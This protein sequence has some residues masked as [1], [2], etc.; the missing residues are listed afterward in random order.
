MYRYSNWVPELVNGVPT[1]GVHPSD[2]WYISFDRLTNAAEAQRRL[3]LPPGSDAAYRLEFEAVQ[4]K[5]KAYIPYG[6]QNT[7]SVLEPLTRDVRW[8]PK[9][10]P[11][12]KL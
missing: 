2:G 6:K 8:T 7:D 11:E 4:V 3:L 9:I 12:V 5:D 1:L 10:G